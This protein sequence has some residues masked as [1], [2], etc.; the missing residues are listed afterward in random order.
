ML[1]MPRPYMAVIF[2]DLEMVIQTT[3]YPAVFRK[4]TDIVDLWK[5]MNK[6]WNRS[7]RFTRLKLVLFC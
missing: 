4:G 5:G 7:L 2:F 1:Q 3:S 6:R